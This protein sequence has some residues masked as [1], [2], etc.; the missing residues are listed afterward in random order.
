MRRSALGSLG[1]SLLLALLGGLGC[2][3]SDPPTNTPSSCTP[4]CREGFTC[5][6][7][8]CVSSCNPPCEGGSVCDVSTGTPRCVAPTDGGV[9]TDTGTPVD[10]GSPVDTGV[11]AADAGAL[12]SGVPATDTGVLPMD[13]PAPLDSGTPT[14]TGALTDRGAADTGADAGPCG[15]PGEA[16]CNGRACLGGGVCNANRCVAPTREMGECTS[17]G[18]CTGGQ[19]CQGIFECTG[20][21]GCWRCAASTGTRAFGERCTMAS[22]CQ[23]GLCS[24]GRC[25]VPCALGAAGDTACGAR[26]AGY[27]CSATYYRPTSTAP[28]TTLGVCQQRC[29]RNADCPAQTTC[30]PILNYVTDRMDFYCAPTTRTGAIGAACDPNGTATCQSGL[31]LPSGMNTGFCTAPCVS[32]S[33]CTTAAPVCGPVFWITPS[34]GSQ[35][36]RGCVPR[37]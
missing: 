29:Q 14:D 12:D 25:S 19:Q 10:V 9:P 21:R 31:C 11:P 13:A 17:P 27:V 15:N 28:I 23:S 5:A 3:D 37:S 18:D 22:E 32:E 26:G 1:P 35:Q 16:C 33:D 7:G 20:M 4:A 30:L 6:N 8:S 24:S 36:A 2:G 34:G